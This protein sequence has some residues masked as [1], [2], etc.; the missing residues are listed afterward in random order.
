M[1]QKIEP[2]ELNYEELGVDSPTS[3]VHGT[4][5][6]IESAIRSIKNKHEWRQEGA[7]LYCVSCP[8]AHAT[9]QRFLNYILM[10]TDNN[11]LPILRKL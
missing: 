4:E 2:K 6:D 9:E 11:G 5:A 10:G 7:R 3:E 8:W 1:Q